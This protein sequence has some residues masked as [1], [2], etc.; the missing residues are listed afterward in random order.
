MGC[1]PLQL[2]ASST[3]IPWWS[4]SSCRR[5][6]TSLWCVV[7]RERI[8]R[9]GVLAATMPSVRTSTGVL[10]GFL[11]LH[12]RGSRLLLSEQ[13]TA[14]GER[15]LRP[16]RL[17]ELRPGGVEGERRDTASCTA[18]PSNQRACTRYY[19]C[20]P[21]PWMAGGPPSN[22]ADMCRFL[23]TAS[24]LKAVDVWRSLFDEAKMFLL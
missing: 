12:R 17:P 4:S 11:L 1:A 13:S 7:R 19:C 10:A 3:A 5:T 16:R 15:L 9:C 6:S 18:L 2:C 20:A 21:Q 8:P 23:P 24:Y 22:A 14:A